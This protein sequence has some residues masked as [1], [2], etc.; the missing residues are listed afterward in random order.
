MATELLALSD[1]ELLPLGYGVGVLF[2]AIVQ[3]RCGS[4]LIGEQLT[5]YYWVGV[6]ISKHL[7]GKYLMY[8]IQ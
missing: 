6:D 3:C 8:T 4:G 2:T 1:D 7:L 5:D